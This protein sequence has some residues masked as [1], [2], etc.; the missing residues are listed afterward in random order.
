MRKNAIAGLVL[1][2]AGVF[3]FVGAQCSFAQDQPTIQKNSIRVVLH[4][5]TTMRN[6]QKRE[7][8]GTSWVPGI[9]FRVNG[10]IASGSQLYVK[11]SLPTNKNWIQFDCATGETKT[12]YWWKTGC[13]YAYGVDFDVL[14]QKNTN[15]TG[16]VEFSIHLRNELLS[17]DM[18]LFTGK[19]NV[20]KARPIPTNPT[21]WE[22]FADE[23]WRIPIGYLFSGMSNFRE[24][25]DPYL[26]VGFWYRGNPP[27]V[28][29]HLFYQ[30]KD[31]SKCSSPGNGA[32]DWDPN[33]YQW[34][35]VECPFPGVYPGKMPE[36]A[37]QPQFE[38]RKNPGD[39]EVKVLIVNHLAR[40]IKFTVQADGSFNNGIASANKLGV[41]AVIVPV[42]VIGNQTTNWN[43]LA[44]KTG[45][46]Y[47]NPLTEFTALP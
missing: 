29:A 12:N 41:D 20:I 35:Y 21:H 43:R 14:E 24:G 7:E 39:Y 16:P 10:P 11:F 38:M 28:E 23:D 32:A 40:S 27:D 15:V 25:R 47:G 33:K 6:G 18:V 4:T 31:L 46:F 42:Q 1:S 9:E 22:Y 45:A 34:G 8:W 36:N 30:G 44:W 37:Y 13:G 5:D 3:P 19:I 26:H 17:T 2:F